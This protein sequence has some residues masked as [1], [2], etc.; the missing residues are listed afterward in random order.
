MDKFGA[1]IPNSEAPGDNTI[2]P[3]R[4]IVHPHP[5]SNINGIMFLV[6]NPPHLAVEARPW[7]FVGRHFLDDILIEQLLQDSSHGTRGKGFAV[8]ARDNSGNSVL[9]IGRIFAPDID[10]QLALELAPLRFVLS[11]PPSAGRQY[12]SFQVGKNLFVA[13]IGGAGEDADVRT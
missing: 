6:V 11:V 12:A 8:V 3:R 2:Y 4:G 9:A 13:V 1:H 5:L 10:H 7:L